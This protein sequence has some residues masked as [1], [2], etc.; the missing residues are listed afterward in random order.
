MIFQHATMNKPRYWRAAGAP[1]SF[2][3]W[4][5]ESIYIFRLTRTFLYFCYKIYV[6]FLEKALNIHGFTGFMSRIDI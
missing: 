1:K 2:L 4:L 6:F 3:K 5:L